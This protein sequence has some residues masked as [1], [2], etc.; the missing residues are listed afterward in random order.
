M[1]TF[2]EFV[3]AKKTQFEIRECA[4]LMVDM[5]V[6]PHMY[7]YECLKKVD[8][9]L[10]EG[11]WGGVASAAGNVW[12]G[13]KQFAGNVAQG[14]KAGYNQAADTIS[15]PTAKFDSAIRAMEDLE[16][17]L[18]NADFAQF[19]SSTGQGTVAQFVKMVKDTL[20]KDKGAMP[21]RTDTKVSQPYGTRDQ[22]AA[23]RAQAAAGQQ[24]TRQSPVLGADGKPMVVPAAS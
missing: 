23:Q 4:Q 5:D 2:N 14:A 10:A 12:Q 20:M 3:E 8:P 18:S 13:I 1:I 16:K 11:F 6:N 7:I 9:V 24:P 15:G 19:Q 17:V 21:Q 22:V